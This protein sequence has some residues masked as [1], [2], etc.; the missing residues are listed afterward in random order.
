MVE[1]EVKNP[2]NIHL[3]HISQI[4]QDAR[5]WIETIFLPSVENINRCYFNNKLLNK[6]EAIKLAKSRKIKMTTNTD[7]HKFFIHHK[8]LWIIPFE[9]WDFIMD[10]WWYRT[11]D[12]KIIFSFDEKWKDTNRY[13][14]NNKLL[15]KEEAEVLAKENKI[16]MPIDADDYSFFVYHKKMGI[17]PF[18]KWDYVLTD[19]WYSMTDWTHV[20][21]YDNSWKELWCFHDSP[22]VIF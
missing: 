7:E 17:V 3:D 5:N 21:C 6:E 10:G 4:R 11:T 16:K 14:F 22:P 19:E 1:P 9:K 2:P 15:S 13:Y 8:S 20:F 12:W 18:Q